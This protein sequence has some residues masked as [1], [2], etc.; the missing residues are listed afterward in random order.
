M[1][2]FQPIYF[3]NL[4]M[5]RLRFLYISNDQYI[6]IFS[7]E[8]ITSFR[9]HTIRPFFEKWDAPIELGMTLSY[10]VN[11]VSWFLRKRPCHSVFP[12]Q[13]YFPSSCKEKHYLNREKCSKHINKEISW[14]SAG[15]SFLLPKQNWPTIKLQESKR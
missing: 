13:N 10:L 8:S 1:I 15:N 7:L 2:L 5:N 12:S 11:R 14:F 4:W 3:C 6:V 9:A